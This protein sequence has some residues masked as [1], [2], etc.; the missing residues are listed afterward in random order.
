MLAVAGVLTV[1][2]AGTVPVGAR[3]SL[4]ALHVRD[5][6]MRADRAQVRVGEP[7][8]LAIH[9]HVGEDVSALD[10]LVIP[11]VGSMQLLGDE[12]QTTH[13]AGGTDVVE[14]LTLEPTLAGRFTFAPAYLDAVDARDGR[15]KRFSANR[16]VTVVVG[17]AP[18]LAGLGAGVGQVLR[19]LAAAA[20]IVLGLGAAVV[21][22]IAL[23]RLRRRRRA[24]V[25]RAAPPP[26][27]APP[28]V[29]PLPRSPRDAVAEALRAYRR[30][31]AAA[32][33]AE[34]RAA[35]FAAA[36]AAPGATLRDALAATGDHGLRGALLAAE[37]TAFGPAS[38]RD[39]AAVELI[40][41]TEAWLR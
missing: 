39:A 14:T 22:L 2:G 6:S 30:A 17:T 15:P 41:A 26:V 34:L 4:R 11:D 12:R 36:G 3:T 23:A 29:A 9:V 21:A 40:D 1:V 19:L 10:E 24:A 13:A 7:F 27:V 18:P 32:A 16:P 8:H 33:L 37:R 25:V 35:L 20:L 38:V 5:L 31:P 28:A